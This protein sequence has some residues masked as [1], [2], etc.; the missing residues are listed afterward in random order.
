MEGWLRDLII[1]VAGAVIGAALLA[2]FS[3][4]FRWNAG[5]RAARRQQRDLDAA[6]WRS[7]DPVKRQRIFNTYL[8]SVLKFFIIGSILIGVANALADIEPTSH[9]VLTA[10][11]YIMAVMDALAV[12]FYLAT[13]GEILQFTKLVRRHP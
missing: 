6:D 4:G 8:F 1:A 11:D 3:A 13:L 12:V 9:P 5:A 2:V 7:G 10:L